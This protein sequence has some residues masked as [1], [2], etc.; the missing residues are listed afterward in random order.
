MC[1]I[2]VNG[3]EALDLMNLINSISKTLFLLIAAYLIFLLPIV[4][5][6]WGLWTPWPTTH[7]SDEV[8]AWLASL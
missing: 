2:Q 1:M 3:S 4:A 7:I 8:K 5:V 6:G